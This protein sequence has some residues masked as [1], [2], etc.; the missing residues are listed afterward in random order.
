HVHLADSVG[1][2]A[3]ALER[4]ADRDGPQLGG[5]NGRE[6]AE[7]RADRRS[8]GPDDGDLAHGY[9]SF[10]KPN[11]GYPT[12]FP[13]VKGFCPRPVRPAWYNPAQ[14]EMR[15][16]WFVLALAVAGCGALVPGPSVSVTTAGDKTMLQAGDTL[17]AQADVMRTG[18]HPEVTWATSGPTG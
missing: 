2:E 14:S 6:L 11:V 18:G 1:G 16:W 5:G 3:G 9:I 4:G 13:S 8:G 7:K 10:C 17:V 12:E 15:A